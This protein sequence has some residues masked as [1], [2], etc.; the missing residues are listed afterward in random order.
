[1]VDRTPAS[2]TLAQA[3]RDAALRLRPDRAEA[4]LAAAWVAYHCYLDY[5][6]A[7]SEIAI[8]RRG[9]PNDASVFSLPAYIARR[10]GHWDQC[11]TNLQRAVE[12][13]PRNVWL[14]T[15]VAQTCE[16]QRRFSEA[17]A[18]WECTLLVVPNDPSTRVARALI[19]LKSRAESQAGHEVTQ[20]LV[21]ED[22]GAVDMIAELWLDLAL[23]R[24]DAAEMA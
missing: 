17:A 4:H 23:C 14:L 9:L 16:F 1:G 18:A 8:A 2:I 22:P 5:E 7:L 19:D 20:R 11:M 13:D 6:T 12:L 10:Q 3:A 24:R 21:T 15:D